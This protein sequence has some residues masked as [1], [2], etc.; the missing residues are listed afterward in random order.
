MIEQLARAGVCRGIILDE[1]K[2]HKEAVAAYVSVVRRYG[3]SADPSVL[4]KVA[5]SLYNRALI[6]ADNL[7]RKGDAIRGSRRI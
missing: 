2:R 4:E 3:T 1:M 7:G 6:L 5:V